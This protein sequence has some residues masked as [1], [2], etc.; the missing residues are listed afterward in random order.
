MKETQAKAVL[1]FI[2]E[3]DSARK[4]QLRK[5]VQYLNW[6]G[7]QKGK[8]SLRQWGVDQDTVMSWAGDL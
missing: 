8:D 6:E 2:D 5:L 4:G 3:K 7:T 1:A